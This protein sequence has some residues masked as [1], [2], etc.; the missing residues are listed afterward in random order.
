MKEK[1][2]GFAVSIV[3]VLIVYSVVL[4]GRNKDLKQE[5]AWLNTKLE[6]A[7][8][9]NLLEAMQ[10]RLDELKQENKLYKTRNENLQYLV[11]ALDGQR[12]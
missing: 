7:D 5:I 8:Q 1:M 6:Y 10:E 12:D 2:L 11:K 4:Y 3:S 9:S